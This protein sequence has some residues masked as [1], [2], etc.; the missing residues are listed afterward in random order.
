MNAMLQPVEEE[1]SKPG[2]ELKELKP[3]HKQMC[4]MIAQGIERGT[5]AKVLNCDPTYVSN[6]ARQKLVQ[7][8]IKDWCAFAGIQLEAQ[9]VKAVEVIGDTMENGNPKEK[10]QAARLQMEATRRIGSGSGQVADSPDM[11]DRLI[12]LSERLVSLL[13]GTRRAQTKPP[14]LEGEVYEEGQ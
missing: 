11:N 3:W 7:D 6:L 12:T 14:I 2:W 8:Y 1:S 9:F 10:L 13:E 5:I 4:S